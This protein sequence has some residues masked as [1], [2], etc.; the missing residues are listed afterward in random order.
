MFIGSGSFASRNHQ[1]LLERVMS[2]THRLHYETPCTH[3]KPFNFSNI[4]PC[5][6][7]AKLYRFETVSH[8]KI[9]KRQ[10]FTSLIPAFLHDIRYIHDR[11]ICISIRIN[12]DLSYVITY[13]IHSLYYKAC[14]GLTH[15]LTLFLVSDVTFSNNVLSCLSECLCGERVTRA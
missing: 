6:A 8:T 4:S 9:S 5:L 10:N 13:G 12:H 3:A 15:A 1:L 2:F 11:F 7:E 14:N